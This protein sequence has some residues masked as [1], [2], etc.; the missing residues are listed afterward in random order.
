MNDSVSAKRIP[1]YDL[2]TQVKFY[3]FDSDEPSWIGGIAFEDKIICGCCGAVFEISD[4]YDEANEMGFKG[5]P[6]QELRKREPIQELRWIDI[7]EE[8]KGN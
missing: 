4:I 8:I 5:E 7:S 1:F 2:P 3:D 6:T